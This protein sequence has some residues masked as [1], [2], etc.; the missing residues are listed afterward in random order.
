M[1]A[2]DRVLQAEQLVVGLRRLFAHDIEPGAH[3]LLVPQRL[4]E[5]LLLDNRAA[6]GVDQDRGRFHQRQLTLADQIMRREIER[7]VQ[8][9]DIR[10]LQ[11]LGQQHKAN[12]ERVLLVGRHAVDVVIL[13]PHVE[14]LGAARHLLADI[15]EPHN[16]ERLVFELIELGGV[17]VVAAPAPGDDAL[18]HPGELAG[19]GQ[20]QQER[21]LGDSGRVGAAI[22]ADRHPR[23]PRR[24]QVISVVAGAQGL[25][26]L[27]LGRLLVKLRAVLEL[28]G[29][30]I[31][32]GILEQI[33]EFRPAMR[34]GHQLQA[35][36]QHVVRDFH[37]FVAVAVG[38]QNTVGHRARLLFAG[39]FQTRIVAAAAGKAQIR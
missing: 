14:G 39:S 3:D 30:D 17:E 29:A 2:E 22:V 26:E 9:D 5:R 19:D 37:R 34:R 13:D 23:G 15:A 8:A 10:R 35:V 6:A 20:H 32:I 18:V 16:A 31:E 36:R 4:V 38:G 25:H 28:A 21:V 33:P 24:F 27:Q 11:Q 7:H 1:R 12:A